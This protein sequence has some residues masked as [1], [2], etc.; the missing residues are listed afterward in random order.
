MDAI[1]PSLSSHHLPDRSLE[2]PGF[3]SGPT[4]LEP[5][6]SIRFRQPEKVRPPR[7]VSIERP[8]RSVE[9]RLMPQVG[10]VVEVKTV[11][12]TSRVLVALHLTPGPFTKNG[13]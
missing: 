8:L 2:P 10:R 1:F 11:S 13:R 6:T 5:E 7:F 4:S 3:I 12:F 9:Y